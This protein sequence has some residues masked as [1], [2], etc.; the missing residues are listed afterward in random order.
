MLKRLS[1]ILLILLAAG[2]IL[3][4]LNADQI[5][6]KY[7]YPT[8]YS[9]FVEQAAAETG[10]DRYLI[11]AV[12]KTES[13]FDEKAESSVGARGL[14]QLMEDAFDWVKFRMGDERDV[15]Y[16]DMYDPRYNIEYG[17][18]LIKLLYEEYGD[19]E[20]ALA[21]YHSGRGS[22]NEW[23]NDPKYSSDGKT[24]DEIPSRTAKHYVNKVMTAYE[25]YT[26]LYGNA[27]AELFRLKAILIPN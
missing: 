1:G 19:V 24:L 15:S 16:D 8:D 11:Y 18:Y 9:G 26:N 21:A 17:S 22:V 10:I 4:A 6:R 2:V 5:S 25:G 13:G 12:I 23:L 3:F 14:M 20:T 7:I 27:R